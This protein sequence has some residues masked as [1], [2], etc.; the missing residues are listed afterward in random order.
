MPSQDA[1]PET[2][3]ETALFLRLEGPEAL[4][5][6]K[7]HP[8]LKAFK[9]RWQKHSHA[10]RLLDDEAGSLRQAG[11]LC[12]AIDDTPLL[13]PLLPAAPPSPAIEDLGKLQILARGQI[14]SEARTL[15][16]GKLHLHRVELQGKGYHALQIDGSRPDALHPDALRLAAA[17]AL[18]GTLRWDGVHPL[19]HLA[20]QLDLLPSP[21][22]WANQIPLRL[23]E[24][25]LEEL[26]AL[27]ACDAMLRHAL[28]QI[29]GN[30]ACLRAAKD[31]EGVHQMRVAMRR[32]RSVLSLHKD[33]LPNAALQAVRAEL[34]WLNEPLGRRRDLDV[35]VEETLSPLRQALPDVEALG[36]LQTV[37]D[38]RRQAAHRA[39][40]SAFSSARFTRLRL[41]L[42]L[43][44]DAPETAAPPEQQ[45]APRA[46]QHAALLLQRRRRKL[47]KLGRRLPDLPEPELHELRI[48]AKK[49]RYAVEFYRPFF[50]HKPM[51]RQAQVH[52]RAL[53]RLQDALGALNDAAVGTQ[54]L[55]NVLHDPQDPA[56]AAIT[57]W[58]AARKHLQ[59]AGLPDAWEAY[60]ELKPFWKHALPQD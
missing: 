19:L 22:L 29:D 5:A 16:F 35:F 36:D 39:L 48:L 54:L 24:T 21:P 60:A 10:L 43:L 58:F 41:A 6:L 42:G 1:A 28:A 32:L 11:W 2:S 46:L 26:D 56:G 59:L 18:D 23:P 12:A 7:R 17:L 57:G 9:G 3:A 27:A 38:E 52:I 30:I 20:Q 34:R 55:R 40:L 33:L 49:L 4:A 13:L 14:D 53:A 45:D 8:A 44:C 37:L 31:S 50:A 25:G 47:K 15:P 51:R